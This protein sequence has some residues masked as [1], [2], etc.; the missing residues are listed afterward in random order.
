MTDIHYCS[1]CGGV[2]EIRVPPDDDRPRSV[3]TE[4]G[5][6]HYI[7]P[8]MVVGCIPVF[9]DQLL[10]CKRNIEPRKGLWT[11]PAGYLENHETVQEGAVRETFEETR[12][13][14]KLIDCYRLY[15]IPHV[16]QI[17]LMFRSE[18]TD[19]DFG[20]TKESTDVRLFK[21]SEIPWEEIAFKVILE[22][23]ND[24]LLDFKQGEFPF[25]VR[26]IYPDKQ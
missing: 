19:H 18:L 2:M 10:L 5:F 25:K 6:I 13:R 17:Y 14:V 16:S 9:E 4:C 3:C 15:N 23:L 24:F 26:D 22:T 8:K 11:L 20:P 12:A 7:N 21:H 1:N